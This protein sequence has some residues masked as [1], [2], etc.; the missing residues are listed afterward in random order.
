MMI[1]RINE[2]S[3]RPEYTVLNV[4]LE[5]QEHHTDTTQQLGKFMEEYY[6]EVNDIKERISTT[7]MK[8]DDLQKLYNQY[9]TSSIAEEQ[10]TLKQRQK[11]LIDETGKNVTRIQ[12]DLKQMNEKT[13]EIEQEEGSSSPVVRIRKQQHALLTKEFIDTL[14]LYQDLQQKFKTNYKN[15]LKRIINIVNTS[16]NGEDVDEVVDDL[17]NKSSI[18]P[19]DL[20]QKSMES[21]LTSSQKHTLDAYYN[22]ATEAHDD[23]KQIE[24]SLRQLH[25]MFVDFAMLVEQQDEL[26]DNIEYNVAATVEYVEKGIT[27][28]KSAQ[29]LQK[30]SRNCT[31]CI[32]V[33]I[34]VFVIVLVC[35][36]AAGVPIVLKLTNVF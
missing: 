27:Q 19:S 7:E 6:K 29:K 35:V 30:H 28:I 11:I 33:T 34:L 20:I 1:D 13:I 15:R 2:L 5:E 24:Y 26:L 17:V 12:N 25:Q 22:E 32:I 10:K 3:R 31:C 14:N 16:N 36:L 21:N 18:N 9:L 8:L 23:L 4:E